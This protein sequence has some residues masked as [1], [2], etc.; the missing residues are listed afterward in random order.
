MQSN[1]IPSQEETCRYIEWSYKE[2]FKA[3]TW[4]NAK[5]AHTEIC[6]ISCPG[7][8]KNITDVLQPTSSLS[9]S[10][11]N[12]PEEILRFVDMYHNSDALGKLVILSMVDHQMFCKSALCKIFG[13]SK[14][15]VDK[16]RK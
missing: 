12:I 11:T 3:E 14:Y 10:Q 15:M 9:G 7:Q 6:Q 13:C 5:A 8:E 2:I 1:T 16:G 4:A